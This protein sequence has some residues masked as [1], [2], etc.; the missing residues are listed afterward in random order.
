MML[1]VAAPMRRHGRVRFRRSAPPTLRHEHQ[2]VQI[3]TEIE[4][5]GD[6]DRIQR[7]KDQRVDA[8]R[9]LE[10]RGGHLQEG[11]R[12]EHRRRRSVL[13]AEFQE[14]VEFGKSIPVFVAIGEPL[15]LHDVSKRCQPHTNH[16]ER[17]VA[18]PCRQLARSPS[19]G[20]RRQEA[21]RAE[22]G[23]FDEPISASDGPQALGRLKVKRAKLLEL[24]HEDRISAEAFGEEEKRLTAQMAELQRAEVERDERN[25]ER[26]ELAQRF[27]EVAELL[28]SVG[29]PELWEEATERERRTL[30]EDM[31]DA[32]YV[33]PDHLRVVPEGAPPLRVELAEV[34]LRPPVGM[35]PLVS[36]GGLD[37]GS[38]GDFPSRRDAM[39]GLRSLLVRKSTD[40]QRRTPHERQGMDWLIV[41]RRGP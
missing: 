17:C 24:Y 21:I 28:S 4:R 32:V 29:F 36:E 9:C 3:V 8:A 30:V 1:H 10:D 6:V 23:R 35:G 16:P 26:S 18:P 20:H 13:F 33:H 5:C 40:H 38:V 37:T 11:D 14:T 27:E 15:R 25:A 12:I 2:A 39:T 41:P 34:G 19:G 22:L 7:P 31:L